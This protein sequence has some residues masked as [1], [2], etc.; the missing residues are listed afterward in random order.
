MYRQHQP[1]IAAFARANPAGLLH[2]MRFAAVSARE[3]F[4][5]VP[6]VMGDPERELWGHKIHAWAEMERQA[7]AAYEQ[8]EA[9]AEGGWPRRERAALLIR[10]LATLPGLNLS[11]AGFVA[12]MAYG[13]GGCLDSVNIQRLKLDSFARAVNGNSRY[14]IKHQRTPAKRLRL[15][16]WYVAN[17][18]RCGGPGKLWDDWCAE[19]ALRYPSTF[20]TAENA[21]AHHLVCL[22]LT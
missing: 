3:K 13:C 12:Q 7:R 18:E 10:Y 5:N 6:A 1:A 19:I 14:R 20:P 11:K 22:G 15:A 21:S 2:V 17:T 8:C 16:R 4:Y 9:I